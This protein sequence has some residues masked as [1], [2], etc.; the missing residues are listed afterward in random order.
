MSSPNY[1]C[2]TDQLNE[3]CWFQME[4]RLNSRDFTGKSVPIDGSNE[5][6]CK[7]TFSEYDKGEE[8]DQEFQDPQDAG[9]PKK[10]AEGFTETVQG[11]ETTEKRK[12]ELPEIVHESEAIANEQWER[13]EQVK[14]SIPEF[15]FSEG[16]YCRTQNEKSDCYHAHRASIGKGM[17]KLGKKTCNASL[18]WGPC[19]GQV[20]PVEEVCNGKDDNCNGLIDEQAPKSC[21]TNS[22]ITPCKTGL[23]HCEKGKTICKPRQA[24]SR[25]F[26]EN[27]LDDDCDGKVDNA[28]ECIWLK[29]AGG[30]DFD[31]ASHV[32]RD[33]K[34]QIYLVGTIQSKTV[35]FGNNSLS[36][37][38]VKDLF[39]AKLDRK[40]NW[41]WVKGAGTTSGEGLVED[42]ALDKQDNLFVTGT[43]KR[44]L[45]FGSTT[46]TTMALNEEGLFVAKMDTS[47]NWKWA[48]SLSK[49]SGKVLGVGIKVN[50]NGEP[51]ILGYTS[52]SVTVGSYTANTSGIML[53]LAG[54]ST[55]GKWSWLRYVE[56]GFTAYA[57]LAVTRNDDIIIAA[58]YGQK[59]LSFDGDTKLLPPGCQKWCAVVA[60]MDKNKRWKW[61]KKTNR[62]GYVR[63]SSMIVTPKQD[64]IIGV[65]G[66]NSLIPYRVEHNGT[67]LAALNQSGSWLWF[68]T[69]GP[70]NSGVHGIR[71]IQTIATDKFGNVY[72]SGYFLLK[73]VMGSH[74]LKAKSSQFVVFFAKMSPAH[75]WLWL[76]KGGVKRVISRFGE[77]NS[78]ID[79]SSEGSVL[80]VGPSEVLAIGTHQLPIMTSKTY[81]Y[82]GKNLHR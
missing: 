77:R 3:S 69:V 12:E 6:S 4:F 51:I 66:A 11:P 35:K 26:C 8:S 75:K 72:I 76:K 27:G 36:K 38:G 9:E 54:L 33:S 62:T 59:N 74:E 7:L 31:G 24:K 56:G 80:I 10:E 25:E 17:C 5:S 19:V 67:Y 39:V 43:F 20:T 58:T 53:F 37:K 41:L 68:Q 48:V 42:I 63:L 70:S 79:V 21:K 34:G 47:G 78:F 14:E 46:L 49:N 60:K 32:I 2:F 23:S 50:S 29:G 45:Q 1:Q 28:D 40:G 52:H 18:Q 73:A 82:I 61:A 30:G 81:I 15:H 57:K 71:E 22:P 16:L 13:P 44:R 65:H 64:I 55:L